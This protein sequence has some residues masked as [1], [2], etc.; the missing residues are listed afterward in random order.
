MTDKI[1]AIMCGISDRKYLGKVVKITGCSDSA[2]WYAD[3][4]GKYVPYIR[5]YESEG[6]HLC[7]EP[8]GYKNIVRFSDSELVELEADSFKFY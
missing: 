2:Y 4:V 6:T 5:S 3:M 7:L 1:P 8:E